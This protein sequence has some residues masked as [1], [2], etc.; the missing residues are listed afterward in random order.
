MSNKNTYES[1]E[2]LKALSCDLDDTIY[3]LKIWAQ[4]NKIKDD[5]FYHFLE[6][7]TSIM[8]TMKTDLNV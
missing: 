4:N 1:E 7:L 6:K 2:I 5:N 8:N 3:F